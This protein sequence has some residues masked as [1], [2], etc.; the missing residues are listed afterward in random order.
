M[1]DHVHMVI[2]PADGG[3]ISAI[4]KSVK[5]PVARRAVLWAKANGPHVLPQM[6]DRQ[7]N[8]SCSYRFWQRGG[9][10]DRNLRSSRNVHEKIRY[11]HENPLRRGLVE[12]LE[13][14]PWSS[15]PTYEHGGDG[16]IPIDRDSMPVV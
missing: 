11:I 5:L 12:R 8:G 7:P 4:L 3:R 13:D 1:P 2:Y 15:W 9:G 16:L 10:Y 14:W 6:A